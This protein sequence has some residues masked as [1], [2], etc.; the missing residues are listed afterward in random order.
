M[1]NHEYVLMTDSLW[2]LHWKGRRFKDV[3]FFF[4]QEIKFFVLTTKTYFEWELIKFNFCNVFELVY[5][6]NYEKNFV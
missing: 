3:T 4:C 5:I 2:K 1:E 6:Q